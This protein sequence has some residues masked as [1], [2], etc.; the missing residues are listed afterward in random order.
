VALRRVLP[1]T[2]VCF[3][4]SLL[5]LVLRL[6]EAA[7]HQVVW[8]EDLLAELAG[9]WVA[10]GARSKASAQ[11]VCDDIR[12][13]FSDQ[14][15]PRGDY[16]HL[17]DTMP[18]NDPADHPH[19]AAAAAVAPAVLLTANTAD[20]PAAALA[21]LGVTVQTPDA[22]LCELLEEHGDALLEVVAEMAEDRRNPTMTVDEVLDALERSGVRRLVAGLRALQRRA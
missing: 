13:A 18:G 2:N 14:E 15:V 20:F 22:Y 1:D 4:I 6:D 21:E 9:V 17:V 3:P 8:T 7:F 12:R 5:D 16:A 19:A 10:K 11:K